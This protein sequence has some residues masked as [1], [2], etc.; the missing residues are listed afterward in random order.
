MVYFVIR[1][2]SELFGGIFS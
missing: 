2:L 1:C